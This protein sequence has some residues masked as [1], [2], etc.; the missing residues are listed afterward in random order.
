MASQIIKC[1]NCPEEYNFHAN[2]TCPACGTRPGATTP[3]VDRR[4]TG[5]PKKSSRS[6]SSNSNVS[7]SNDYQN[8]GDAARIAVQSA[9]IVNGYGSGLQIF[10]VILGL[11]TIIGGFVLSGSSGSSAFAWVGIIVGA[12]EIAI[13]AVQGALFRMLSNYVIARLDK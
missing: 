1:M 9:R 6:G 4:P 7:S 13:F 2:L 12:L 11:L 10:G 3:D 5:S 8:S